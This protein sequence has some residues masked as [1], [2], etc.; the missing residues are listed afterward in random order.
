MNF[1]GH[2]EYKYFIQSVE[3]ENEDGSRKD[4]LVLSHCNGDVS[5]VGSVG[6]DGEL[7]YILLHYFPFH[8]TGS[9]DFVFFL[10]CLGAEWNTYLSHAHAKLSLQ[11]QYMD[12][13]GF[14]IDLSTIPQDAKLDEQPIVIRCTSGEHNM[15]LGHKDGK[16]VLL[17]EED[18]PD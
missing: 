3:G 4:G 1:I 2:V 6:G 13:E 5:L 18:N 14:R 7:F 8:G 9:Q 16:V 15:I 11:P 10:G 12:G 17:R